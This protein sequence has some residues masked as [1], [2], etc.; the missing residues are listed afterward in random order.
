M[1]GW[2]KTAKPRR[3]EW[4]MGAIVYLLFGPIVWM[5]HFTTVYAVQ[6]TLC[7]LGA[8]ARTIL[9][10]DLVPL[11]VFIATLLPLSLLG[12]ALWGSISVKR[13]P[14]SADQLASSR[15][16]EAAMKVLCLL[17]AIG[18]IWTAIAAFILHPCAAL[19]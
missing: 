1:A 12:G 2:T 15:F 13:K 7:A 19:R 11:A 4:A 10:V 6:S 18:I 3:R 14:G 5:L 9:D 17:A 8:P 16:F